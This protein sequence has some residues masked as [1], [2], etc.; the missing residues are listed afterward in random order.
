MTRVLKPL[1]NHPELLLRWVNAS[2]T[3]LKTFCSLQP[4]IEYFACE[5][6]PKN[7]S[8]ESW[9]NILDGIVD[10]IFAS[11]VYRKTAENSKIEVRKSDRWKHASLACRGMVS[12]FLLLNW[13]VVRF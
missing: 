9:K 1:E 11:N 13:S 5:N 2:V 3:P 7:V 12:I 8:E 6:L 4:V 10:I